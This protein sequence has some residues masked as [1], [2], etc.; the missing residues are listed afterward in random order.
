MQNLF[1][2]W[3]LRQVNKETRAELVELDKG[4]F[5]KDEIILKTEFLFD[6]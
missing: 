6:S 1:K 2:S 3:F 5:L 4:S